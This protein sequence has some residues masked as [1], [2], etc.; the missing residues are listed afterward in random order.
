MN[1]ARLEARVTRARPMFRG[2]APLAC[3][4]RYDQAAADNVA[5]TAG[6][7]GPEPTFQEPRV[8]LAD[9]AQWGR[10]LS[11]VCSSTSGPEFELHRVD[12]DVRQRGARAWRS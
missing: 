5:F 3:G 1:R 6:E 8:Y 10:F 12:L 9:K 4:L 11:F 2:A 7:L